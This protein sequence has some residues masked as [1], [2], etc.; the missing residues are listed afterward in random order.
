MWH[1]D[2]ERI[3]NLPEYVSTVLNASP[4]EMSMKSPRQLAFPMYGLEEKG[5]TRLVPG[6]PQRGG[7]CCYRHSIHRQWEVPF[8]L[9]PCWRKQGIKIL[10][11]N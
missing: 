7:D 3:S 4:F 1:E 8:L 11:C 5:R 10:N 2:E 6:S 9:N